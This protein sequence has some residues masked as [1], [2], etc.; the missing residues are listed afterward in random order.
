LHGKAPKQAATPEFA[1]VANYAYH[2]DA[3][4]FGQFLRSHC[5]KVLG[6]RHVVDHVTGIEAAENGDIGRSRRRCRV[7]SPAILFVDCS[8]YSRSCWGS[9]MASACAGNATSFQ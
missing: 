1:A 7:A 5:T 2:L 9:T 8:G 6:V 4:K 3:G